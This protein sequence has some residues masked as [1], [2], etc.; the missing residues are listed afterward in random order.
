MKLIKLFKY[1]FKIFIDPFIILI[2]YWPG[3]L[4][5][6]IRY[7]YYKPKLKHLGKDVLIEVGVLFKN[8]SYISIGNNCWIDRD[9]VIM[10][11]ED[12]LDREKH[13][14]QRF[15]NNLVKKGEVIIGDNVHVGIG[16][17]ISGI[18]AGVYIG[19]NNGLAP[20][21]KILAFSHHYRSLISRKDT[22]FC[23]GSMVPPDKQCLIEGAIVLEDNVSLAS[24]VFILPGTLI[25]K[26]SVVKLYS[27]VSGTF[28]EN[29]IIEGNPA[30]RISNR[31]PV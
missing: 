13:S 10:A 4:G 30:K 3:D 15:K 18:S 5:Y 16:C 14:V 1:L 20:G 11:G 7:R 8:P 21:C 25:H 26:N 12:S 2:T 29:S 19:N 9:V 28:E 24:N 6:I 31:F 27:V 23:G 17:I 22:S